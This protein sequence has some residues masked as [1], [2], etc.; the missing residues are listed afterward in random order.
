MNIATSFRLVNRSLVAYRHRV[1]S[2]PCA[3]LATQFQVRYNGS[4]TNGNEAAKEE[5]T[6]ELQKKIEQ[7]QKELDEAKQE[8]LLAYADR[9]NSIRIAKDDVRKA[10]EYG[11]QKFATNLFDVND[12]L[13]RALDS[14]RPEA[15]NNNP[16]LKNFYEGVQMTEKLL[17]KAYEQND[18]KKFNPMGNKFDP[19]LHQALQ[20]VMDPTKEAGTV[21]YVMKSGYQLKDRLLRAASVAVVKADPNAPKKETEPPKDDDSVKAAS[22]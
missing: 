4:A 10:K 5:K 11:I 13:E 6:P 8:V 2:K 21:C 19:N 1:V 20:E 7:L 17:L 18:I 14:I 12:V 9:Q 3:T 15:L 22:A 16:D